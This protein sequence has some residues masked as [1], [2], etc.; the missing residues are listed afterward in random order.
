MSESI[1]TPSQASTASQG[2]ANGAGRRSFGGKARSALKVLGVNLLVL[3]IVVELASILLVHL[4]KWPGD[5]PTY[6]VS[7]YQFW[8]VTNPVFGMWHP[9]NGYFLHQEGCF[10][11][12]YF[13]NSYGA[14]DVERS[15]HS[16]HPRTLVL[17][18]SFVEGF[19]LPVD[20]RLSNVLEA[21]TGR[22]HLNFGTGGGFS[23][24]QYALV[25]RSMASKFDHDRVLVGVLPDNDFHEMDVAWME[26]HYPGRYFPYYR[27][28][29]S[30]GYMGKFNPNVLDEFGTR[31]DAFFRAYFATYHVIEY[32][33]AARLYS[34]RPRLY[35]GYNDYSE[36]DL[37]RLKKALLDI[38]QTADAGG[39]E[40]YVFLIP[41]PSDFRRYRQGQD[42][43]GPVLEAWGREA[44]IHV[45]DLLPEI[46]ARG[47]GDY[48]AFFLSCDDHWSVQGTQAAADILEP[49]IYN[50]SSSS[51][52]AQP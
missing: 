11:F 27:D 47:K 31:T 8:A 20:K 14:R 44:E 10:S 9:A 26:D 41:R 25:Y 49:W 38:K 24:L 50:T 4:K 37:A 18:D 39:A 19:G 40:V 43:L 42:R 32:I 1:G 48:S 33:Q 7:H 13:T 36:T 35:S 29:F 51:G 3:G 12:E 45:K 34:V 15:V 30:V 21:R 52:V 46:D 16:G 28:D 17:G 2:P 23:P 6:H 22:E 5:R